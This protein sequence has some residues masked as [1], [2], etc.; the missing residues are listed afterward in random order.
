MEIDIDTIPQMMIKDTMESIQEDKEL[1]AILQ[2]VSNENGWGKVIKATVDS[3]NVKQDESTIYTTYHFECKLE[4]SLIDEITLTTKGY[5]KDNMYW[6][7]EIII[8]E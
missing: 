3:T 8:E 7:E 2:Y 1:T 6:I 4:T 5:L